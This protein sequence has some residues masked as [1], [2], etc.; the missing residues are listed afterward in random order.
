MSLLETSG[1]SLVKGR[2]LESISKIGGPPL[3]G[4]AF[5]L[6]TNETET[7]VWSTAYWKPSLLVM[8][9]TPPWF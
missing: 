5:K 6:C 8:E 3:T 2:G 9:K 4:A 7:R 1:R